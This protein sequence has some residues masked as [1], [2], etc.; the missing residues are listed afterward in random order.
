MLVG[1]LPGK[2]SSDTTFGEND[3]R[4]NNLSPEKLIKYIEGFNLLKPVFEKFPDYSPAQL[5]LR[6]CPS[7]PA[8]HVVIPG[9]KTERQVMENVVAAEMDNI[10]FEDFAK[11]DPPSP[12]KGG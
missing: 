7:Q 9:G 2:F 11:S 10:P 8:C 4:R 5:S 6:F 12:L 1:L 3:H